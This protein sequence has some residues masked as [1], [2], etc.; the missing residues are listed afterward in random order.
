M[1]LLTARVLESL[2]A[3]TP[4]AAARRI[5]EADPGR[6]AGN[7]AVIRCAPVALRWRRSGRRL[8]ETARRS[9]IVT[10]WDPR[11]VWSVVCVAGIVALGLDE[12]AVEIET[13]A[14]AF[15][16]AGAPEA[17]VVAIREADGAGLD[18]LALDD[19]ARMGYTLKA[20]QVALWTARLADRLYRASLAEPGDRPT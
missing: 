16:R 19:P 2:A 3:G 18:D 11:C 4:A 14:R 7:G 8:V 20:M 6:P 5:W 1:G 17:V 15:E 12:R 13:L 9:A 10:H